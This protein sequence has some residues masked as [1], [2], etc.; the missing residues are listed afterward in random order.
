MSKL[1]L[2]ILHCAMFSVN[3]YGANY[4][5]TPLR[6]SNGLSRNGH[7]VYNFSYRDVARDEA[8]LGIKKL[9]M[10]K[11]N[12][13]LVETAE[14]ISADIVLLGHAELIDAETL[15]ELKRRLPNCKIA[16]WWVDWWHNLVKYDSVMKERM[17]LLDALFMT[18]DPDYAREKYAPLQ[19]VEKFFFMPNSCD[20]SMDSG[21]AHALSA[22]KHDVVFIGRSYG[23]RNEFLSHL[24]TNLADINL[25]VYGQTRKEVI[26]GRAYM[27]LISNCRIGINYQ[28]DNTMPLSTSNRMIHLAANGCLVMSPKIPRIEEVFSPSEVVYFDTRGDCEEKI[29]HFLAHPAEAEKIAKAAQSRAHKDY[30]NKSVA[31][32]MLEK[33]YA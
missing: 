10:T 23:E 5:H 30:D 1:P 32:D 14:N 20:P 22:H 4:H 24:E 15:R 12:R 2:R 27:E 17:P 3:K 21:N 31:A 18:S 8:P 9:G 11:M 33:I 25:G 7:F 19:N 28:R 16:M 13:R 6:L 29:R 26:S